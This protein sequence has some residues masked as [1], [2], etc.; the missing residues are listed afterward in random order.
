LPEVFRGL[1]FLLEV[2]GSNGLK[3]LQSSGALL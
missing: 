1:Q 2:F 3:S